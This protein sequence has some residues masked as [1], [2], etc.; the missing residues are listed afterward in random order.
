VPSLLIAWAC[1]L[2]CLSWASGLYVIDCLL[3]PT[4]L[5]IVFTLPHR[6]NDSLIQTKKMP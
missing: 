5:Q 2:G 3:V 4:A 6:L 1:L